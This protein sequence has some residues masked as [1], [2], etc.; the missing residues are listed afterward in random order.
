MRP[1]SPEAHQSR[2]RRGAKKDGETSG[3]FITSEPGGGSSINNM[4]EQR[5]DSIL[6]MAGDLHSLSTGKQASEESMA[7]KLE[8]DKHVQRQS[9]L[10]K[11]MKIENDKKMR[12]MQKNGSGGGGGGGGGGLGGG[13]RRRGS[14]ARR[15]SVRRP[16][17]LSKHHVQVWNK[18]F[19]RDDPPKN[20]M[21]A[22]IATGNINLKELAAVGG[23]DLLGY[24]DG[25]DKGD[26]KSFML[27]LS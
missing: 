15:N 14:V 21:R 3:T 10:Q 27:L 23:D 7:R 26:T 18:Q 8:N 2:P 20:V 17:G 13:R 9:V 19:D 5:R 12:E 1:S 6:K 25:N 4:D 16:M 11:Q 22:M 24:P